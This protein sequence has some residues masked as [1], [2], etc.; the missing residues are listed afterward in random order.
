MKY[1]ISPLQYLLLVAIASTF[2]FF[3]AR[4]LDWNLSE[5]P[6]VTLSVLLAI[7]LF[8]ALVFGLQYARARYT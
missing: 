7:G 6:G 3:S 5:L 8:S 2:T 4:H 1:D